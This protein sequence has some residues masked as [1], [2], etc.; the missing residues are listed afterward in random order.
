MTYYMTSARDVPVGIIVFNRPRHTARVL[1]RL[2][3]VRPRHLYVIA[4]GPRPNRTEDAARCLETR[5]MFDD[6]GW[7]CEVRREF[8]SSNLGCRVRVSSGLD[9][10]FS[11]VEEAIILEDDC[12]PEQSFFEFCSELLQKYRNDLNVSAITGDNFQSHHR[13]ASGS[14]YFSRYMHVWGWATW[15][16]AWRYFDTDLRSWQLMRNTDWLSTVLENQNLVRFWKSQ[17]DAVFTKRLDTWDYQWQHA[18]WLQ[19]GLVATPNVNLVSNIGDGPDA[20]HTLELGPLLRR[21]TEPISVPLEHPRTVM[22]DSIADKYEE[23][24]F[25]PSFARRLTRKAVKLLQR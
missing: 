22:R 5:G 3:Q 25:V 15:R 11:Q 2:R 10:L 12:V 9:W 8:A 7:D 24:Q 19:N 6:L 14:Y 21:S 23:T 16:R 1:E 20:T 13:R 18:I 4:D 17:F